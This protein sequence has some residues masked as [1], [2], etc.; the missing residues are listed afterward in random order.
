MFPSYFMP[1]HA[2]PILQQACLEAFETDGEPCD[3]GRFFS[4]ADTGSV[5]ELVEIAETS[6]TDQKVQALHQVIA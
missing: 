4:I 3:P 2:L 6:T 1:A 5:L